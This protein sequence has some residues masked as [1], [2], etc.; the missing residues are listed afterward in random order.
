MWFFKKKKALPQE[1]IDDIKKEDVDMQ[2]LFSNIGNRAKCE[3][4]YKELAKKIHPDK[5][6]ENEEK[7]LQ[8]HE[9]FSDLQAH[10]NEYEYML[11]LE[12]KINDFLKNN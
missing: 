9:L 12:L 6:V 7:S 11:V 2:A 8:A 4:L 1:V 10:R 5:F 3:Q